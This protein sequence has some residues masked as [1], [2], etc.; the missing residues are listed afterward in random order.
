MTDSPLKLS[1]PSTSPTKVSTVAFAALLTAV[2]AATPSPAT[3][4]GPITGGERGA[5]FA[6]VN[7]ADRGYLTEEYFL[8]GEATAYELASGTHSADGR[9]QTRA[10]GQKAGFKTRLLVVRPK[11]AAAFNGTVIVF[12]LNVTAGF[13][14]GSASDEALRGYAWVGVSAQKVGVHGFPQNPGGLKA[15]DP[16]RYGSLEHPGDAYSYDI[17]T[18]VASAMGP[19][20]DRQG[21]D[22]MG[23]LDVDRLI[24][25]GASQSAARLRT[26]I[27][28]VHPLTEVFDGFLPFIDFGGIV[29]FASERGGGRRGRS[30][31]SVRSD[32]DV[33]VIV[34]NSETEL[35]S[36]YPV[37]EPDSD[38]FR[39]WEVPGTSHVSVARPAERTVDGSN[40]LSYTPVYQAAIRH[41]HLWIRDGVAPPKMPRV[42]MK[43]GDPNP[44]VVRDEHGNARGGIRLPEVEAPTASHSGFGTQR[45]GTRFGFLY[46]AATDFDSEQLATLYPDSKHYLDAWN[47]ALDSA[48]E[49]GMIL[50]EDAPTMRERTAAWAAR[51]DAPP[52]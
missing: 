37:R 23:G 51:L 39:L 33:P 32:L 11:D 17:F 26:Y 49:Q 38:R 9:W 16:K 22:P 8:E 48:I 3:L 40:W 52:R 28:G 5:P 14:L 24:A 44:E 43:A 21:L 7:V 41:L 45:E 47:A 35:N 46:G 27:N 1:R 30:L 42:E 2:V 12:W 20:R 4:S 36:Y 19:D 10:S 6:A 13:E 50:P 18:Q 34:V 29:P 25:A 31:A 15:W